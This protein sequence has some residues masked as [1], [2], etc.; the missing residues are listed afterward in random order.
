ML[1]YWLYLIILYY[2]RKTNIDNVLSGLKVKNSILHNINYSANNSR[3][4]NT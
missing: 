1:F 2:I 4:L 3:V